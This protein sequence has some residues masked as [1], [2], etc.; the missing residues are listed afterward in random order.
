MDATNAL[1]QLQ[2]VML[3]TVYNEGGKQAVRELFTI[4]FEM[5]DADTVLNICTN[6][7]H[8]FDDDEQDTIAELKE[9]MQ[10]IVNEENAKQAM[11][12]K[13]SVTVH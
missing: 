13:A 6:Y 2:Q 10:L 1:A 3:E 4:A 7:A 5:R 11:H 8:C 12:E 9:V